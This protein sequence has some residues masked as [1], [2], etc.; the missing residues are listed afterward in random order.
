M[1]FV[2]TARIIAWI[3]VILGALRTGMGLLV[4][5][6]F[7]GHPVAIRRY[8]GSVENTGEAIEQGIAWFVVGVVIGVLAHI[9]EQMSLRKPASL[10]EEE[11]A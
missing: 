7:D 2:K 3:T 4:A 9:G 11:N 5:W 10:S 1:F 8:L 6:A